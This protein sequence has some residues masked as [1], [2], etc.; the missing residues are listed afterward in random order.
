MWLN[1]STVF[2]A[3]APTSLYDEEELEVFCMSRE[4]LRRGPYFF[5]AIVGGFNYTRLALEERLKSLPSE[6]TEWSGMS[7]VKG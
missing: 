3:H 1:S 6:L 4:A 2:V 5:K 7:R